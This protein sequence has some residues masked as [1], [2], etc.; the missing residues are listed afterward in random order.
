MRKSRFL[1]QW[2]NKKRIVDDV[3]HVIP[4]N[5]LIPESNHNS[6]KGKGK[7]GTE[8]VDGEK[9]NLHYPYSQTRD[10]VGS[11]SFSLWRN[12]VIQSQTEDL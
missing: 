9:R 3:D 11:L 1:I 12:V 7:R 4:T 5:S 8:S 2:R 6:H 10:F